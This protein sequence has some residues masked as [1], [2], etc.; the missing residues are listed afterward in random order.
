LSGYLENDF[1]E[2]MQ[3]P[4][5]SASHNSPLIVNGI[6]TI[7]IL[8]VHIFYEYNGFS[9]K[10]KDPPSKFKI[11]N[12]ERQPRSTGSTPLVPFL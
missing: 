6:Q 7:Q 12:S 4:E 1:D 10:S 11:R 2:V 8:L 5:A 3:A 9:G